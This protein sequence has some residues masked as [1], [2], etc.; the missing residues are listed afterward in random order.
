M[1]KTFLIISTFLVLFSIANAQEIKILKIDI[2]I[3]EK[4]SFVDIALTLKNFTNFTWY[5]F[6]PIDKSTFNFSSNRKIDCKIEGEETTLINCKLPTKN[7]TTVFF[8]FFTNFFVRRVGKEELS[9]LADF[10][11]PYKIENSIVYVKLP[12]GCR[13]ENIKNIL[14]KPTDI[15][16]DGRRIFGYWKFEN[17]TSS[18]PLRFS[19]IF[20]CVKKETKLS[21]LLV[22]GYLFTGLIVAILL[23]YVFYYRKKKQS[24]LVLSLIDPDEKKVLEI[25]A[26]FDNPVNQK[27]IV[28]LTNFSKAKVSRIISSLVK[29]KIIKVERRGRN[30][31]IEIRKNFKKLLKRK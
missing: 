1:K 12:E 27:R 6:F 28:E 17:L 4:K 29:R 14:P 30:N 15:K 7:L 23:A 16:S 24:K 22:V 26:N 2:E 20:E 31:F 25:L 11:L 13:F 18:S 3:D 10:S 21:S 5:L 19:F 9:F 8:Q